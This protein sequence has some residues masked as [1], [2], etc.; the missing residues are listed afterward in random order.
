MSSFDDAINAIL[1]ED[2]KHTGEVED[3]YDRNVGRA[4]CRIGIETPFQNLE[5]INIQSI[6]Q[7][8]IASTV[9]STQTNKLQPYEMRQSI[10]IYASNIGCFVC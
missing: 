3:E 10:N 1:D 9:S 5:S 4:T 8:K 7:P 2:G 6:N